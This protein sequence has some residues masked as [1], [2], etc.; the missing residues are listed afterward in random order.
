MHSEWAGFFWSFWWLIFP[1]MGFAFG[2][3]GMFMG[4]KAHKDRMDL[5]RTYVQQGKDPA[6]IAKI[7]NAPGMGGPAPGGPDPYWGGYGRH[8]YGGGPWGWGPWG[9]YGPYR[10]WRRFIVFLCLAIGFG[11]ASW[12]S[13]TGAEHAFWIVAVI[14]GVLAAGTFC[15]AILS[16][17]F[18][19]NASKNDK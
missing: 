14:M 3:F 4:Y 2:A 19:A 11:L 18:A 17:I 7:L 10:E 16:T 15:F 13:D 6:E 12:Y 8:Y 9:R 1:L 5:M